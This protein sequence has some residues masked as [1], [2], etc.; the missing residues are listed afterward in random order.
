VIQ[1]TT[2]TL[3]FAVLLTLANGFLDAHTYVARGGVFANV[4][5]GNVVL[6]AIHLS[7]KNWHDSLSRLAPIPAFIVGVALAAH[8][9]SGRV[10]KWVKHPL[11]WTMGIQAAALFGFG[12]V[13]AGVPHIAVTIPIS[14]LAGM[15]IGLFRSVRDLMYMPVATTGNLMRVVEAGYDAF[16]EKHRESREAV[17]TYA[18]LIAAF[19]G[20]AIAGAFATR[21]WGLHAIWVPAACLAMTLVLFV[22]DE[23]EGT[24]Q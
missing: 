20:G 17:V 4:Q 2:I 3:R 7:E 10:D 15:Q 9:K 18:A 16:V 24:V 6:F 22:I 13:P 19:G 12:F 8:I 14:F 21:F 23:R 5:T 1:I 11:R